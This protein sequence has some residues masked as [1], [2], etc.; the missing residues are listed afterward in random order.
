MAFALATLGHED[1]DG[2][3]QL[4]PFQQRLPPPALLHR[5]SLLCL[6]Q[7][8]DFLEDLPH[9]WKKKHGISAEI[10]SRTRDE[11]PLASPTPLLWLFMTLGLVPVIDLCSLNFS[12]A[13]T[14][15]LLVSNGLLIMKLRLKVAAR[16]ARIPEPP[17][18]PDPPD[19]LRL[20]V[21]SNTIMVFSRFLPSDYECDCS[22]DEWLGLVKLDP[23]FIDLVLIVSVELGSLMVAFVR[24]F[25]ALCRIFLPTAVC[26]FLLLC[27][28]LASL[29]PMCDASIGPSG[30]NLIIFMR[31][32]TAVYRFQYVITLTDLDVS[33]MEA[34]FLLYSSLVI[35]RISLG[36][37]SNL[38][39]LDVKTI[40]IKAAILALQL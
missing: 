4:S 23:S 11:N 36:S 5:P 40:T 34:R 33:V 1:Q 17:D 38:F 37:S 7:R 20:L 29:S 22:F 39:L 27:H 31:H 25:A 26:M 9:R 8:S 16:I 35:W 24:F 10:C 12:P 32:P 19:P 21:T 6:Y 3:S 28:S 15:T 2:G 30:E 18:P 14:M 13:K